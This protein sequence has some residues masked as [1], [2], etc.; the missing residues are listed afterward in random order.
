MLLERYGC[1]KIRGM[2]D[3]KWKK[4]EMVH[5]CRIRLRLC[6][7]F[8][9]ASSTDGQLFTSALEED[10]EDEEVL[11]DASLSGSFLSVR[12]RL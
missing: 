6:L 8:L 12:T 9:F 10:H 5:L 2:V 7:A 3:H 4:K 11:Q 1:D